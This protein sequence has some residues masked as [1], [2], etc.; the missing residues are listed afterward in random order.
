[1]ALEISCWDW[2]LLWLMKLL[3]FSQTTFGRHVWGNRLFMSDDGRG[4]GLISRVSR[5][6]SLVQI[7]IV[8]PNRRAF[9]YQVLNPPRRF[10]DRRMQHDGSVHFSLPWLYLYLTY[11]NFWQLL[12]SCGHW[13]SVFDV[14]SSVI[15]L[16]YGHFRNNWFILHF[17]FLIVH[18]RLD[19]L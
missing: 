6:K 7:C 4:K 19:Y 14:K 5:I 8:S 11:F 12:T 18:M 16:V 10:F 17:W 1:M 15:I 3:N 13:L 9:G 2:T